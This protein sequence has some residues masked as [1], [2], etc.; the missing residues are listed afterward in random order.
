MPVAIGFLIALAIGLFVLFYPG[1][2]P[3]LH[4]TPKLK[5]IGRRTPVEVKIEAPQ[6]V[7]K[8]KVEVVQGMDVKPV[9]KADLG[10]LVSRSP[11]V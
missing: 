10:A 11:S 6:R 5:G 1:A 3:K 8:V 4:V 9:R 2:S 7:T